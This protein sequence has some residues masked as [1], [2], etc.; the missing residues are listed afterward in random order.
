M[1]DPQALAAAQPDFTPVPGDLVLGSSTP[2]EGP[3]AST[4]LIA[5]PA[6]AMA[7]L[8]GVY[9]FGRKRI[10]EHSRG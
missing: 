1:I 3:P 9:L 8:V 4:A 5:M 2:G 7:G 6:G 10:G